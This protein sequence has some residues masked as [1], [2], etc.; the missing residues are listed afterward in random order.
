MVYEVQPPWAGRSTPSAEA[1]SPARGLSPRAESG[2]EDL[3]DGVRSPA[4]LGWTQYTIG[5]SLE[6]GPGALPPG[7][8]GAGGFDR[9]CTKSSRL[10]LDAVHHRQKPL[11]RPGGS[12]PGA[13]SGREDLTDGVRSP[14]AL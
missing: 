6:P 4:A 3:T 9:W 13:E 5:R 10:A 2:R 7:R 12:T 11:A 14:A 8:V 1:S